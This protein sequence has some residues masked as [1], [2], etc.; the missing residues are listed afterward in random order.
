MLH[1]HTYTLIHTQTKH[2]PIHVTWNW[3]GNFI[4]EEKK[5]DKMQEKDKGMS[6][7]EVNM[8][9]ACDRIHGNHCY[10]PQDLAQQRYTNENTIVMMVAG[11]FFLMSLRLFF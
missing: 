9:R 4:G 6:S 7:G 2:T 1:M 8:V 10:K 3:K 5:K 11:F